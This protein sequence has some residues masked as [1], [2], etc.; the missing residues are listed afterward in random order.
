MLSKTDS[1]VCPVIFALELQS[2]SRSGPLRGR[3]FLD[4]ERDLRTSFR[5]STGTGNRHHRVS[6]GN[7]QPRPRSLVDLTAFRP[8]TDNT[9][10]YGNAG[11]SILRNPGQAQADLSLVKNARFRERF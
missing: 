4:H 11:R 9:G 6:S 8:T 10:T 2:G 3:P 1:R 5:L 7:L